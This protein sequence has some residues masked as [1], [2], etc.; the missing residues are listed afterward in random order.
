MTSAVAIAAAA[1]AI[2]VAVAIAAG[3]GASVDDAQDE[4]RRSVGK[5][6]KADDAV[7]L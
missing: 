1:T 6:R 3:A 5:A 4:R 2:V 7:T